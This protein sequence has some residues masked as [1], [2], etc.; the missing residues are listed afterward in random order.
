MKRSGH[1]GRTGLLSDYEKICLGASLGW[2][3]FLLADLMISEKYLKAIAE[4]IAS[5]DLN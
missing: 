5:E 2:R 3:T 4:T 1:T